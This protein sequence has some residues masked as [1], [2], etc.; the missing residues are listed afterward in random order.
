MIVSRSSVLN[1]VSAELA[2]PL[3]KRIGDPWQRFRKT[4][5]LSVWRRAPGF[6]SWHQ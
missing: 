3:N 2:H 5:G 4:R 6:F 1:K